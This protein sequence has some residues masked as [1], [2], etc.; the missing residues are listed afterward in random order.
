MYKSILFVE[1]YPSV[2]Y[3][4][5]YPLLKDYLS[6][7]YRVAQW[8]VFKH[9]QSWTNDKMN[10]K[11]PGL[12]QIYSNYLSMDNLDLKM[13]KLTFKDY[14]ESPVANLLEDE[15]YISRFLELDPG[16]ASLISRDFENILNSDEY[17]EII[18]PAGLG[19]GYEVILGNSLRKSLGDGKFYRPVTIYKNQPNGKKYH[20]EVYRSLVD[21]YDGTSHE[22]PFIPQDL[23]EYYGP[24]SSSLFIFHSYLTNYEI[25]YTKINEKGD[26]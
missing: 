20:D 6:K 9:P 11:H 10:D 7:N 13:A 8:T 2:G 21:S 23:A 25:K 22:D 19:D 4:S 26:L 16:L 15:V 24:D 14:K 17:D 3:L 1:P 18:I 12:N 5:Y